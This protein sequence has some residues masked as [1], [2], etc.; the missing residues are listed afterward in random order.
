MI[1]YTNQPIYVYVVNLDERGDFYA[2]VRNARTG[3]TVHEVRS[4]EEGKV[5]EIDDGF[6]KHKDDLEGLKKYLLDLKM[7]EN[8][9]AL[10]RVGS[11][12]GP[13]EVDRM[14]LLGDH[15]GIYIPKDFAE[16]FDAEKWGLTSAED[17]VNLEVLRE[18]PENEYYWEAWD[19]I[20]A[21]A[22]STDPLTGY[23]YTLEQDGDLFAVAYAQLVE[24]VDAFIESP[25]W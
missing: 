19:S 21:E 5:W 12:T 6:M 17:K 3:E 15:R 9:A 24:G 11:E 18:G 1:V 13:V 14:L 10:C 22:K 8:D 2:D 16:G 7:I 25:T 4:D 20:L 23:E